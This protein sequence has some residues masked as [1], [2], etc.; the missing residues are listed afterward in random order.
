[1]VSED[2]GWC[3]EVWWWCGGVVT[4]SICIRNLHIREHQAIASVLHFQYLQQKTFYQLVNR[5]TKMHIFS[6]T[7]LSIIKV[8][9]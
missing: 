5:Y 1:M 3:R 8:Y 2:I 7:M 9:P 6:C 4:I